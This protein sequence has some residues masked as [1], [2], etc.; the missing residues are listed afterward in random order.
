MEALGT[1]LASFC[2]EGTVVTLA[3][4]LGVGKSVLARAIARALGVTD[5]MPSPSYTLV[6]EYP[7]DPAILHIDLYRLSDA[8][9]FALLGLDESMVSAVSLVEWPDRAPE[10]LR[11]AALQI[12]I[13]FDTGDPDCRSVTVQ[14]RA[15]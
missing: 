10:L 6:E 5:R 3:G 7:G 11:Q 9:E 8:Q 15:Q 2:R 14:R 1:E 4:E 12:T 13:L